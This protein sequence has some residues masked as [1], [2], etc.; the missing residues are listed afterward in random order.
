MLAFV[1]VVLSYWDKLEDLTPWALCLRGDNSWQRCMSAA[2]QPTLVAKVNFDF[3][4]NTS[5]AYEGFHSLKFL[6]PRQYCWKKSYDNNVCLFLFKLSYLKH[7]FWACNCC[8]FVISFLA[9]GGRVDSQLFLSSSNFL[10]MSLGDAVGSLRFFGSV[11]PALRKQSRSC[12]INII[13]DFRGIFFFGSSRVI[14]LT[15]GFHIWCLNSSG[16]C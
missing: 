6:A 10:V 5:D 1:L 3:G 4:G 13:F 15:G 14:L 11:S 16:Q 12:S 9:F 8:R 2:V 7:P